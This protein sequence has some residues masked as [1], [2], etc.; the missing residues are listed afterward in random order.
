MITD[1]T[2]QFFGKPVQPYDPQTPLD[3][4]GGTVYRLALDYDDNRRMADVLEEFLAKADKTKLEALVFGLWDEAHSTGPGDFF[5]VLAAHARELPN[6]RALF[7]GDI[8]YEECEISWIV[9]GYYNLLLDAFPQLEVLR[10]RGTI[11]LE[12]EPFSH[13]SLRELTIESGGLPSKIVEALAESKLP[14]LEALEL[15]LG[16]S[17]Y[18]FDGDVGLYQNLLDKLLTP[19]LRYLGLRDSE[20]ADELAKWLAKSA[21]LEQLDTLDLSLGTIGDIGAKALSASPHAAKLK[22]LDL[23]HHYISEEWQEKLRALGPQVVLEDPQEEDGDD[24]YVAV[25]E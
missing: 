17:D 22:L 21:W 10:I 25:G 19:S 3:A 24:R 4:S 13:D 6:L 7:V 12:I 18:G 9:Q 8:T 20:I 14:K 2:D 16:T 11:E 15:W 1:L 23:T 5:A